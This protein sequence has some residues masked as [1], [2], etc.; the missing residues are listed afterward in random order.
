MLMFAISR[1]KITGA[2]DAETLSLHFSLIGSF[3]CTI[4]DN[5]IKNWKNLREYF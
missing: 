2:V 4:V 3:I 1:L 5:E